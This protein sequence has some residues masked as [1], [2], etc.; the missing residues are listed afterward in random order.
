MALANARTAA[1]AVF[2]NV[3]Y[4]AFAAGAQF[5]AQVYVM[6]FYVTDQDIGSAQ[7]VIVTLGVLTPFGPGMVMRHALQAPA[8]A[9]PDW[10]G[11]FRFAAGAQLFCMTVV[12]GIAAGLVWHGRRHHTLLVALCG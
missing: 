3:A 10:R 7:M 5:A 6:R 12:A 9:T 4:E 8:G 11:Y 2:W 1:R